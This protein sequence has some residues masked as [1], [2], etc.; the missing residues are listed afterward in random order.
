MDKGLRNSSTQGKRIII[1]AGSNGAG[2]T[3]FAREFLQEDDRE[4]DQES[5]P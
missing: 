3:T 5:N 4:E 2:K 1:L